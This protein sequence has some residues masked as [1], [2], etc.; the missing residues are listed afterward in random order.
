MDR[1]NFYRSIILAGRAIEKWLDE[2]E[3]QQTLL[4]GDAHR[5]NFGLF[6]P[7]LESIERPFATMI[8]FQ[9]ARRGS[10]ALDIAQFLLQDLRRFAITIMSNE[11]AHT[12]LSRY[13]MTLRPC[14]LHCKI[15]RLRS[16]RCVLQPALDI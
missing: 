16:P 2:D 14:L 13:Y 12:L 5:K 4:H 10:P 7:P 8:D 3:K 6:V 15:C 9:H 1:N 11:D